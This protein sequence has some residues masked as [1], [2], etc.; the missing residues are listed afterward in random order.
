EGAEKFSKEVKA[1]MEK[2]RKALDK[3]VEGLDNKAKAA[4]ADEKATKKWGNS[5]KEAANEVN[6]AGVNVGGL[7]DKLKAKSAALK[8]VTSGVTG[9]S[10][11]LRAFKVALASTGIGLLVVALGSLVAY[12][13]RSQ[14][15][16]DAFNRG[17]SR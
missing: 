5:L 12:F 4:E 9:T 1:D 14:K 13:Q 8:S 6:I 10:K 17:M 2:S 3:V 11:A 15:G 7:V 16:I